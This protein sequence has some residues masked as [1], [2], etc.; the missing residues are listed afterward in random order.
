MRVNQDLL[1]T[2]LEAVERSPKIGLARL[3]VVK[4]VGAD[5]QR[6]HVRLLI[7]G[8][9]LAAFRSAFRAPLALTLTIE[10]QRLL[11]TL[12]VPPAGVARSIGELAQRIVTGVAV[13]LI[14]AKARALGL[15]FTS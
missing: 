5:E 11:D 2:M 9:Y 10:G 7:Y 8:G 12:R 3:P 6:R 1:R 13:G 15:D 14:V 4:G